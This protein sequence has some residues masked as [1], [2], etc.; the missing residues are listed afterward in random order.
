MAMVKERSA[1][2]FVI[3]GVLYLVLTL[4]AL[5]CLLPFLHVV[6]L[7]LSSKAAINTGQVGLW[8]VDFNIDN[9]KK[10]MGNSQFVRAFGISVGR[11]VVGVLLSLVVVVL[12]AYPLSKDHIRMPGRG[13]YK[14]F[15]L[16]GL[17]FSGG[18]IPTFLALKSLHLLNNYLVYV[19]PGALQIF[20][21]ILM[22]NFFRGVPRELEESAKLDGASDWQILWRIYVPFSKPAIATVA[23]FV[24]VS[25]WN[26]WFDGAVYVNDPTKWPLQTYLYTQVITNP[27]SIVSSSAEA[28]Q[29][30]NLT[31]Q[32]QVST[33]IVVAAVPILMLYPFLQK[34]FTT[35]MVVGSVKA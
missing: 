18:L 28:M 9:Y 12:T 21:V 2:D 34:Y 13:A 3:D 33:L 6:A 17:L 16:I 23:L 27:G 1:K 22:L 32:G 8:P 31:P 10:V 14:I 35:G 5:S 15:L 24:A 25:Q 20:F 29:F 4:L 26:S 30:Q 19:L 7:S 11:V